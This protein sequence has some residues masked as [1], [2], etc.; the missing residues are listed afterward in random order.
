[1]RRWR[2]SASASAA[3]LVCSQ[4]VRSSASDAWR[5]V[6]TSLASAAGSA[7]AASE[8]AVACS[9]DTSQRR[10]AASRA[11]WDRS[12]RAVRKA[13]DALVTVVPVRRARPWAA[14]RSPS[15]S[16]ASVSAARAPASATRVAAIFSMREA[17]PTTTTASADEIRSA[18]KD[19]A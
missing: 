16:S 17:S 7:A 9:G 11:G 10:A 2:S 4:V 13:S 15:P 14:L 3:A 12:R 1:M 6:S 19:L 8:M 18:S 5:D